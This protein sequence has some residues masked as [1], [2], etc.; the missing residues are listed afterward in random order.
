MI[1]GA[2]ICQKACVEIAEAASSYA[3]LEGGGFSEHLGG[4]GC[5]DW[6]GTPSASDKLIPISKFQ[7]SGFK[8]QVSGKVPGAKGQGVGLERE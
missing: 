4:S 1:A 2:F 3:R 8:V 5:C 7:V 6:S